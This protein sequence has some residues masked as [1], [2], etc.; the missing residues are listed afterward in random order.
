MFVA[1][2]T[3]EILAV[4]QAT[5]T[6]VE[7]ATIVIDSE[8]MHIRTMDPSH[9][10]LI[11]VSIPY[12]AFYDYTQVD[13]ELKFGINLD[14]LCKILR[15]FE[16][17]QEIKFVFEQGMLHL[18]QEGQ[19]ASI[20]LLEAMGGTTPLPKLNFNAKMNL[21]AEGI[22]KILKFLAL[23]DYVRIDTNENVVTLSSKDDSGEVENKFETYN[24][25][26]QLQ[27]KENSMSTYSNEYLKKFITAIKPVMSHKYD[28]LAIEYSTKMPMKI[29]VR[30]NNVG[31]IHFYLAPR[32]Q[33]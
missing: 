23:K 6:L 12:N 7:E 17:K 13:R 32:V 1:K 11:D 5:S 10:A 21:N 26:D 2:T 31:T 3:S 29:E 8:G 14:E 22:K 28:T 30:Y 24:Y 33:D 4:F 20:R 19:K 25:L 27:I 15:T 9:V 18:K 16:Q